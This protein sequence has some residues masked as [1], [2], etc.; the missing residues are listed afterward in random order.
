MNHW[1]QSGLPRQ[2]VIRNLLLRGCRF[3][4]STPTEVF[5]VEEYGGEEEFTR[6]ILKEIKTN[7]I[8]FDIGACVGFVSV[9]AARKGARVVA[10]E[11]DAD[12]RARLANNL[13]LNNLNNVQ[14]VEW[15]VSDTAGH[16]FLFS[17]G[18]NGPSPTLMGSGGNAC[19]VAT[20][21]I[22]QAMSRGELPNPNV[23]KIDIEGAEILAL[24]GMENLLNSNPKPRALFIELHPD[25]LSAI[26]SSEKEVQSLI[27][28]YGYHKVYE[29][30]R[31]D[32]VHC[33]YRWH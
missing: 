16:A 30:L 21:T 31:N 27:E 4:V 15:A 24:H 18:T 29:K 19:R 28:S 7:D 13:G 2:V 17:E 8:L 26:G 11:P 22:D 1:N 12:H 6:R 20:E 32:Q 33:H 10:F 3:E 9:H 14:V 23:I 5:R 25:Q